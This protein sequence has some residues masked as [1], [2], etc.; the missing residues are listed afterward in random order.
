M[1]YSNSRNPR[2]DYT[3]K[4]I[5]L[6]TLCKSE[7]VEDFSHCV[8]DLG[9]QN[10]YPGVMASRVGEAIKDALRQIPVNYPFARIIRY[11][12]MPDHIHFILEYLQPSD[13]Q[14]GDIVANFKIA[15]GNSL[16]TKGI[17]KPGYHDR[18]LRH[19]GQ[20]SRMIH[21]VMD[22]PRR[23]II[24]A[25]HP[26]YFSKPHTIELG[27]R[28]YVIYGN[29]QLL[30][31]PVI[32]QV[33]VSRS[34]TA[35]QL[36][37]LNKEWEDTIRCGGVL[38]SPFIA[39]GEKD[40]MLKGIEEGASLI[41]ITRDEIRERFKPSGKLFDLC[42]EG[43]LLILSTQKGVWEPR[44]SK[45]EATVMNEL[46][47]RLAMEAL[48][49]KLILKPFRPRGASLPGKTDKPRAK[50]LADT[51]RPEGLAG[52]PRAKALAD[53]KTG[54]SNPPSASARFVHGKS[55]S[56]QQSGKSFSSQP[57]V[58]REYSKLLKNSN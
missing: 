46:A 28:Q 11:I 49:D 50:A 27:N 12:V 5:Y 10:A 1:E 32:S 34:F 53:N 19:K 13:I 42:A 30:R 57:V 15:V 24:K 36:E 21:Y 51:R 3:S 4:S 58:S 7:G 41:L 8:G 16:G 48:P 44:I 40:I 20:L 55:F 18:I 25:G 45:A 22:N 6:L 52:L 23:R 39:K 9:R 56:S 2:H 14:L 43:R 29:F 17:F 35:E 31:H 26:E 33:R 37:Q 47:C 38:V 54:P